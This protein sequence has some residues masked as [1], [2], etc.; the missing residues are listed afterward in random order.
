MPS[1]SEL[2][3]KLINNLTAVHLSVPSLWFMIIISYLG[4]FVKKN[5]QCFQ[6]KGRSY[7]N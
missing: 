1:Y 7:A 2:P 6:Q 3:C 5:I 4:I